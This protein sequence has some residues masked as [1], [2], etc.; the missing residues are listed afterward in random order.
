MNDT[1]RK[2]DPPWSYAHTVRLDPALPQRMQR[3]FLQVNV[4]NRLA[5]ATTETS[6]G[7]TTTGNQT[8]YTVKLPSR[9]VRIDVE[10]IKS[11]DVNLSDD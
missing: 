7:G 4:G 2:A 10:G 6:G 5:L 3:G 9:K 11:D 8:S 1:H